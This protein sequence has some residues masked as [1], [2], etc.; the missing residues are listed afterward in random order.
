MGQPTTLTKQLAA[1]N[2]QAV[3]NS[4]ALVAAGNLVINGVDAV[5]GVAVLDTA[6]RILITSAGNDSGINFTVTGTSHGGSPIA[7]TLAGGNAVAVATAQDFLTVTQVAASGAVATTVEVGTNS[8]GSTRW[9]VPNYH[10]TPFEVAVAFELLSGAGTFSVEIC[11]ESVLPPLYGFSSN[12]QPPIPNPYAWLG[13]G[14]LVA[15]AQSLINR[16]VSGIRLT[17]TA[18][19]GEGELIIR[20]SGIRN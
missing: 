13:M 15:N 19:A 9:Y 3:C 18:G 16:V 2:V 11:D 7:E 10:I 14:G 6:R 4:Q 17:V 12:Q 5:A 20:Q 1:A 8:T